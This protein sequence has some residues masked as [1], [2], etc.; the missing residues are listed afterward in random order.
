MGQ[1]G[2]PGAVDTENAIAADL[3]ILVRPLHRRIV[4]ADSSRLLQSGKYNRRRG[5]IGL[6]LNGPFC[7]NPAGEEFFGQHSLP[8]IDLHDLEVQLLSLRCESSENLAPGESSIKYPSALSLDHP[9]GV[10]L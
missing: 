8:E 7:V 10:R 9:R 1:A 2:Y 4:I 3:L 5:P 6:A